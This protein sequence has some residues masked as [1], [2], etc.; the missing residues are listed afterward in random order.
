MKLSL[1]DEI[2]NCLEENDL[3]HQQDYVHSVT[4]IGHSQ[5]LQEKVWVSGIKSVLFLF[6]NI[7]NSIFIRK[8]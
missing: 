3:K 8:T 4:S 5:V 6:S 7:L 1:E 2:S